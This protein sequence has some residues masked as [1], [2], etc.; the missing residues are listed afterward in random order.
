M[1]TIKQIHKQKWF[2]KT[3]SKRQRGVVGHAIR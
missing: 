1:A 3:R 2:R